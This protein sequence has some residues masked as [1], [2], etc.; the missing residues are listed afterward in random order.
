MMVGS[1]VM[2]SATK[3][4]GPGQAPGRFFTVSGTARMVPAEA[5]EILIGIKQYVVD[6]IKGKMLQ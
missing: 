4:T 6:L 2:R 5:Q 3:K 1:Q